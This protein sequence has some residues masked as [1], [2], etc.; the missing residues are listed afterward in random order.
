[1][2]L[3]RLKVHGY[4]KLIESDVTI[5]GKITAIVGPN[6][7]GKSSLLELLNS[8]NDNREISQFERPRGMETQ[9]D[10]S[11]AELW[12]RLD[13]DDLAA[14]SHLETP[15]TPVWSRLYKQYDGRLQS[16]VYPFLDRDLSQRRRAENAVSRFAQT[17]AAKALER[18]SEED[19]VGDHLDYALA[20]LKGSSE[21]A[22]E[23][24]ER[25]KNAAIHLLGEGE[26]GR[27]CQNACQ[28]IDKF[29]KERELEHPNTAAW[30]IFDERRPR[31][32][33]FDADERNLVSD[34]E[35]S[36]AALDTPAALGNLCD[37]ANLDLQALAD[38]V[39][40][41]DIGTI[42]TLT[43]AANEQL[44]ESFKAAWRQSNVIVR[45]RQDGSMLRVVVSNDSPG[46][47]S[48]AERS[49]GLKSFV[50]LTAFVAKQHRE[51]KR[52]ILLIDEAEQ[53]LHLDAQADLVRM[54]ERQELAM[55][56]I[57]TTH[58]PGCLPSDLGTGIRPIAPT[59]PTSGR[60]RLLAS[61]WGSSPGFNPLLMALGAA[62]AAFTPSR[63]AVLCEGPTEMI[64]LPT[65]I[66]EAVGLER[67]PYQVAP[68]VA[69]VANRDLSVLELEAPRVAYAL[70]GD[71]GGDA[72][73]KRLGDSG[74]PVNR[75]LQIGGSGSGLCVEDLLRTEVY[76]EAAN[77]VLTQ[78]AGSAGFGSKD[79][80][81]GK[82][83]ESLAAWCTARE[84]AVPGKPAIGAA[85]VADFTDRR[86]LTRDGAAILR[87]M[88]RDLI[89]IFG[90]EDA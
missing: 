47:S 12:Y 29:A 27:L 26:L 40:A 83:N 28:E 7:A 58:S 90:M 71:E 72:H 70:D 84:L 25:I 51:G 33:F 81:E 19:G 10:E 38:A 6:E 36:Q 44:K 37:L 1:M 80:G 50:A 4:R 2:K 76:I 59:S 30:R 24:V 21:I 66:R 60:S 43:D 54:L 49:D 11:A 57:Y 86:L 55:Q 89:A 17:K 32:V 41:Q 79:I 3:G 14:V 85:I 53:H 77:E 75:I 18:N 52:L 87:D 16:D 64:L 65:L 9:G 56:I 46:F 62:A 13:S 39:A 15:V 42:E 69:G 8:T 67:L 31:I 88:H 23:A 73:A 78:I 82:R 48:I 45:L 22:D 63:Y 20:A 74:V 5:V 68:G 34:Y 61:F 35:V